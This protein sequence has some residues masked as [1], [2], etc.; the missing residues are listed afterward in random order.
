MKST[1]IWICSCMPT[2]LIV[3]LLGLAFLS[4]ASAQS[5]PVVPGCSVELYAELQAPVK[6]CFTPDGV[7]YVGN[8][9]TSEASVYRIQSGSVSLYGSPL[10]KAG[11]VGY[12]KDGL[13]SGT[14]G[15]VL[16]GGGMYSESHLTAVLPDQTTTR[17]LWEGLSSPGDIAFDST[18]RMLL[19]DVTSRDVY[20]SRAGERTVLLT[21][22]LQDCHCMAIDRDDNIFISMGHYAQAKV[23]AYRSDGVPIGNPIL[24]GQITTRSPFPI[25]FGNGGVWGDSLYVTANYVLMRFDSPLGSPGS[26]TTI[27]TGFNNVAYADMEFGPDGALYVSDQIGHKILRIAPT[28][29]S[30]S[31]EAGANMAINSA[32]Q[33][34]KTIQGTA[35]DPD[36]DAMQYRWLEG[37]VEL[38]AWTPL[39]GGA[40]PLNLGTVPTLTLGDHVLTLEVSD[41]TGTGSD[42]MTL[43]LLNTPP[44]GVL[45]PVSLTVEIGSPF[46]IQATAADFDG[47]MLAF[48]WVKGADLLGSGSIDTPDDG[49]PVAVADMAIG[50][51]D[52][53]FGLGVHAV[54]LVLDDP[55]NGP[56]TTTATV[57]VEDSTVPTLSPVSSESILW[58]PNHQL[59][60]VRITANASDNGG[61]VTLAASVQS[62]EPQDDGGDGST[63]QDWTT[64]IIDNQ[65]GTIDVSLR[66]E[67]SGSGSGRIYTITITATDQSGNASVATVEVRVPHDRKNK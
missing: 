54:D 46:T 18:G 1:R 17:R 23:L 24:E 19:V 53:R 52:P 44:V 56:V 15:A 22:P 11:A 50:A 6:L 36:D 41:G 4:P 7:M 28:N 13:I 35:S 12:D 61:A 31:A 51:N 49:S 45:N 20:Q 9:S 2:I 47:D 59:R 30:P 58:P 32:D 26:F 55:V 25:A 60:P 67:R 62:N 65:A 21:C 16:A 40:A 48:L 8:R 33:S 3:G 43:T 29:S 38:T 37:T 63:D 66:A 14:P 57:T 10:W 64:P 5:L 27:G 39:V 34:L 42:T